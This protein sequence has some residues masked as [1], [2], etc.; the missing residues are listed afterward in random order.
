MALS[1]VSVPP[2][3]EDWE[4]PAADKPRLVFLNKLKLPEIFQPCWELMPML[5]K[6][7]VAAAFALVYEDNKTCSI[8]VLVLLMVKLAPATTVAN[9]RLKG[10]VIEATPVKVVVPLAD[11]EPVAP[12]VCTHVKV[13]EKVELP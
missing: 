3:V 4:K 5:V 2:T 10:S 12:V 1:V 7:V 6:D 11:I 8:R 13:L 9:C